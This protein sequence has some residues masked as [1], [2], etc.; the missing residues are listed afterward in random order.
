MKTSKELVEYEVMWPRAI[1]E[2]QTYVAKGRLVAYEAMRPRAKLVNLWIQRAEGRCDKLWIYETQR[3]FWMCEPLRPRAEL[4]N[5]ETNK[6]IYNLMKMYLL[7]VANYQECPVNFTLIM[8]TH[9]N[10]VTITIR[11]LLITRQGNYVNIWEWLNKGVCYW[12]IEHVK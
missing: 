3:L 1:C 7:F 8:S 12:L 11:T 9:G 6:V 5:C 10:D 4:W 2:D